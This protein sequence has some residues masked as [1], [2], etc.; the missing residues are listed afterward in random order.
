MLVSP[1]SD[2]LWDKTWEGIIDK[3]KNDVFQEIRHM[4]WQLEVELGIQY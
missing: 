4:F 3:A 2:L 1:Y